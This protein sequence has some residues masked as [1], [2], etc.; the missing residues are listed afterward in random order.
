MSW[1]IGAAALRAAARLQLD[2]GIYLRRT[3]DK[4]DDCIQAGRAARAFVR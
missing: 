2:P 1:R 4:D 3:R